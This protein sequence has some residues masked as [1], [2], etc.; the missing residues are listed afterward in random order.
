M[1]ECNSVSFT[2]LFV[3]WVERP[4]YRLSVMSDWHYSNNFV[5]MK[6]LTFWQ[7]KN[8]HKNIKSN[9]LSIRAYNVWFLFHQVVWFELSK[10][11]TENKKKIILPKTMYKHKNLAKINEEACKQKKKK[12]QQIAQTDKSKWY[13][14]F[15]RVIWNFYFECILSVNY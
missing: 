10:F 11:K 8:K 4:N 1:I 14:Q 9:L 7:K 5:R 3:T 12:Y 15:Q 13:A 6:P 2:W